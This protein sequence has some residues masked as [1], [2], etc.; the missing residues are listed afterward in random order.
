MEI[1]TRRIYEPSTANE[2]LRVLLDR[3]WPRGLGRDEAGLDQWARDLAPSKSLRQWFGHDE[4][5]WHE[6]K[7][8]YFAELRQRKQRLHALLDEAGQGPLTLLYAAR[9]TR[10][11]NAL[12]L[13]EYLNRIDAH[14]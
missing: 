2:G 5:K 14:R 10:H 6:F 7:K 1:R 13:R 3:L 12:A 11:N 9:N 4:A 8:R